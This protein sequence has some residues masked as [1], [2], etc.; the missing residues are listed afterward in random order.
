MNTTDQRP[1]IQRLASSYYSKLLPPALFLAIVVVLAGIKAGIGLAGVAV[2]LLAIALVPGLIYK[3]SKSLFLKRGI[4]DHW[5]TNL[6][7]VLMFLG[8]VI[9]Y[10]IPVNAPVPATVAA[11]FVGNA[12]LIFFR[13]WLNVSAHVS[14]ISFSVLWI[15]AN[16]GGGWAW[17]LVLSPMMLF[18]RVSLGEHTWREAL[19]GALL[20]LATFCCYLVATTWS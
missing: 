14:V 2:L 8:A 7:A 18:S 12:G 6:V 9:C 13:R 20:G 4:A 16:F 5:R 1:G 19:S 11:L 3:R 17:L 15:I 10:L